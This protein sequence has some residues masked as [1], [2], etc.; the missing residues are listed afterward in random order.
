MHHA[1]FNDANHAPSRE[2]RDLKIP[3]LMPRY[4][5][6][7]L[8][9]STGGGNMRMTMRYMFIVQVRLDAIIEVLSNGVRR[10]GDKKE[11]RQNVPLCIE[12]SA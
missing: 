4:G 3:K 5:S 2:S 9:I 8:Y 6:E 7:T 10:M 12:Q 1:R 11:K